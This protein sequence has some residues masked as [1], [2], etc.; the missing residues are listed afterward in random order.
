[1]LGFGQPFDLLRYTIHRVLSDAWKEY[2]LDNAGLL[3]HFARHPPKQKLMQITSG[4]LRFNY[5]I[6]RFGVD[7][8]PHFIVHNVSLRV[9]FFHD[10][11]DITRPP[12][13]CDLGDK[14]STLS[15]DTLSPPMSNST[16]PR[17][18]ILGRELHRT[19]AP[20]PGLDV[21]ETATNKDW[22]TRSVS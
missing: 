13:W 10:V 8:D 6:S 7:S 19:G 18:S 22:G 17:P 9:I 21:A 12:P 20:H 4:H 1:M 11:W 5:F 3:D 14:D 16:T 15:D 2:S